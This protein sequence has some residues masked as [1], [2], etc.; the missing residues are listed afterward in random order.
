[1]PAFITQQKSS[2]KSTSLLH[3]YYYL[4]DIAL[5]AG[6]HLIRSSYGPQAKGNSGG[7][8]L[9]LLAVVA[10]VTIIKSSLIQTF[11][12]LVAVLISL[13]SDKY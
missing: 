7:S 8:L 3:H 12:T 10:T 2:M 6:L 9:L 13:T 5:N 4:K 11:V 1:M